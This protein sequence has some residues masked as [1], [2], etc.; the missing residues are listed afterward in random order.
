MSEYDSLIGHLLLQ[1]ILIGLNAVFACTEIAVISIND[2]KLRRLAETGDR[3]AGR[4]L[5]LT[6]NPAKFLATIQVGITLAGFLGSA[7]AADHFSDMFM[8]WLVSLGVTASPAVLDVIAVVVI[9]LILSY[10][11]L[12]FGELVPKRIAMRHS[13]TLGLSLSGLVVFIAALFAPLVWFLTVST[14]VFLRLLGIDPNAEDK[15]LTEEEIRMM[16]DAGNEKG[17]I[18]AGE[19]EMMCNVLEFNDRK[20]GEIMTHRKDVTSL[21]LKEDDAAWE[22][23]VWESK[24]SHYPI[25]DE[26]A[27][28]VVGVLKTR[29]YFRL[30]D[31][32]RETILA[33]AVD[34]VHFVPET[35][36]TDVL[37]R[38]MK[39][40]RNHFA[41]VLDEYGGMNGIVTMNDLLEQLVGELEN[42]TT[43]PVERPWIEAIRPGAWRIRGVTPLT[44]VEKRLGIPLPTGVYGTLAGFTFGLL[45]SIPPDGAT[46]E[47]EGHGLKISVEKIEDHRLKTA[48][49]EIIVQQKKEK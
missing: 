17:V 23:T 48:V 20:I 4:L 14:N 12:I 15:E 8:D 44:E 47:I 34:P 36:R 35:M 43:A 32:K 13:E 1:V 42:D 39:E 16:I 11:T 7:F 21:W 41:V 6:T 27:D 18:E 40:S 2:N 37:F 22:K 45:G 25:C 5:S 29:E 46:P 10:F 31:R 26:T 24:Y 9:T 30:R 28:N 38:E 19:R 3:R 33:G 49:V